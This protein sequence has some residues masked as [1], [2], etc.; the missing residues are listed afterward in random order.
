MGAMLLEPPVLSWYHHCP[1]SHHWG[2][3]LLSSA[4]GDEALKGGGGGG[5]A[6][7]P[8][9]AIQLLPEQV[10]HDGGVHLWPPQCMLVVSQYKPQGGQ[11]EPAMT[12]LHCMCPPQHLHEWVRGEVFCKDWAEEAWCTDWAWQIMHMWCRDGGESVPPH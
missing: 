5:A 4:L 11:G 6:G 1:S 9:G 12:H 10:L 3:G 2:P 8:E 7:L